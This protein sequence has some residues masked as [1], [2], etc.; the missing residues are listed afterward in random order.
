MATHQRGKAVTFVRSRGVTKCSIEPIYFV[1]TWKT[2]T[3]LIPVSIIT[4]QYF[5]CANE[6]INL[7]IVTKSFS[8]FADFLN[9]KEELEGTG[10]VRYVQQ[11][12]A[13]TPKGSLIGPLWCFSSSEIA[14]SVHSAKR[15]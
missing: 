7:G 10:H 12:G 9:W 2:N 15:L 8:S 3:Q 11:R 14:L 1:D 13:A 6:D 4:I 5:K